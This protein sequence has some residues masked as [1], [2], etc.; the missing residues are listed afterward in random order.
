[1]AVYPRDSWTNGHRLFGTIQR[2]L[3]RLQ[4]VRKEYKDEL[5]KQAEN[6]HSL[7]ACTEAPTGGADTAEGGEGA[8]TESPMAGLVTA[9]RPSSDVTLCLSGA[10]PSLM[11]A[12]QA[13]PS[14]PHSTAGAPLANRPPRPPRRHRHG[15]RPLTL[16]RPPAAP[17][18]RS[19]K[20]A[21]P[22][23]ALIARSRRRGPNAP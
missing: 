16:P 20:W 19:G 12:R 5:C 3:H 13:A 22:Q 21:P 18:A 1:M 7:V 17:R 14:R 10:S 4:A 9:G 15:R 8:N 6:A 11:S 23:S 2:A